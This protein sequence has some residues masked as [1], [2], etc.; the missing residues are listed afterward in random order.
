MV[1][2]HE[3]GYVVLLSVNCPIFD[4]NMLFFRFDLPKNIIVQVFSLHPASGH[5]QKQNIC[6]VSL[7][8]SAP[9]YLSGK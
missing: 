1:T 6:K 7:L 4:Q 5:V 2:F 3:F 9:Q 8:L